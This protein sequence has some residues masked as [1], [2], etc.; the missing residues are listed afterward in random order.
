MPGYWEI[1]RHRVLGGILHVDNVTLAW[2]FGLKNLH[3]PGE[4]V[5]VSGMPYDMARNEL[6]KRAIAGGFTHVFHFDS[7]VIAPPDTIHRLLSHNLPVV[8][9]IYCRRSPPHSLPVMIRNGSW[10]TQFPSNS[11]IEVDWVGAGCLLISTDLLKS[12]PP[13]SLDKPWFSWD[14]DKKGTGLKPDGE[15]LSEDFSFNNWCKKHGVKTMVD[16][17]IVCR[18]VGYAEAGLGTLQPLNSQDVAR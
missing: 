7:D 16:T 1:Q 12:L 14:V 8:S 10:V 5:G 9:G 17:G 4:F 2:A 15:C 3:I 6:C 11:L 18:H 13:Q